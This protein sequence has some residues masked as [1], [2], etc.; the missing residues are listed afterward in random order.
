M[1]ISEES[2]RNVM[3]EKERKRLITEIGRIK[4][5]LDS[6]KY[7]LNFEEFADEVFK[8]V[9]R[10]TV[11][12]KRLESTMLQIMD[13]MNAL[14]TK[15]DEGI[16]VRVASVSGDLEIGESRTGVTTDVAMESEGDVVSEGEI[17]RSRKQ[18][19]SE[20][21]ELE[22]KISRLFEKENELLE[23]GLNDPA[24]SEEYEEKARVAREM[25]LD[26]KNQLK[27]IKQELD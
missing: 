15:L 17:E 20:A 13:R 2:S 27:I 3:D 21:S 8:T 16:E 22:M 19:E 1:D 26:L 4:E 24:S 18:L 12:V 7:G 10:Q 23:M 6:F 9:N 5:V 11:V 14:E 25:R